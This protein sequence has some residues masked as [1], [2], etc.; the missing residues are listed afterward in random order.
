[1]DAPPVENST[2]ISKEKQPLNVQ[3]LTLHQNSDSAGMKLHS[4]T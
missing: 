4:E 3:M 1:M 2:K